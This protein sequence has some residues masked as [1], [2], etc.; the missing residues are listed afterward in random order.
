MPCFDKK[1]EAV[2][3]D[4]KN[5]VDTVLSTNEVFEFLSRD[6]GLLDKLKV[7]VQN[8]TRINVVE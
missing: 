7:E 1:L 8:T 3:N 2:R 5:E 6:P 4:N